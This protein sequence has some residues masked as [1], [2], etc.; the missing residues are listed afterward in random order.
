MFHFRNFPEE[1]FKSILTLLGFEDGIL[2]ESYSALMIV[3]RT[4]IVKELLL[5]LHTLFNHWGHQVLHC[6]SQFRLKDQ[7]VSILILVVKCE[8]VGQLADCLMDHILHLYFS[9]LMFGFLASS[10]CKSAEL[11]SSA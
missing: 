5:V 4:N 7:L 10:T 11:L 1:L 3:E 9:H 6:P 2:Q 8:L